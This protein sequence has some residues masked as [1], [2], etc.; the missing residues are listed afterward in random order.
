MG[1]KNARQVPMKSGNALP[2]G[3][4]KKGLA[5]T[6]MLV[7]SLRHSFFSTHSVSCTSSHMVTRAML[8]QMSC[9][10]SHW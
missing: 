5:L 4:E 6:C 10:C 9:K 3:S 7:S 1:V 2:N 8:A